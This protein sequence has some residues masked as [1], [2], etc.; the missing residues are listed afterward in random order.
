MPCARSTAPSA[1]SACATTA[2]SSTSRWPATSP[3]SSRTPTSSPDSTREPLTDEVDVAVIG[4][5]F[6]GLLAGARLREAGV[7]D[8]RMIEKGGDFGGTWYWNR[9]PG[10]RLRRRV[11]RLPA[12]ARGD[13]T[14]SRRRSTP[15][16]RRS[17]RTAARSASTSTSTATPASR[18]RSR[19]CAGTKTRAR[20]IISTNRGDRMRARFVVHGERPPASPEA[21]GH[22]RHRD[23]QGPLVPHQPL[24]LR[25]HRRHVGGRPDRAARQARRHHRH[26]RDGGA[27]RAA[28]R[29][30]GE[31]ALRVP[32]HAR[33][34]STCATTGPTD[35]EWAAEPAARLAAAADGQL[36]RPRFRRLPGR[37]TSSATA[38]PTSSASCSCMV[39]YGRRARHLAR[40]PARDDGAR[41]LREDGGDPRARRSDRR[42]PGRP[43]RR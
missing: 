7:E 28:S 40:G 17:W 38:G 32:A 24:G 35:P 19:S 21:A 3:T 20:W 29:R 10:R 30:G 25:L 34:R 13:R 11:L 33:H 42:R 5:G 23:V 14:T 9:Y 15:A 12:A 41:R 31:A 4:G 2:T 1:T 22:P 26:R 36:Q 8:I 16:R 18:P 37:W 39:Q 27:V 43:P 6:G